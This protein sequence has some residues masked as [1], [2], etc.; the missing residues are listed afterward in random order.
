MTISSTKVFFIFAAV[1]YLVSLVLV[2][3]VPEVKP[4]TRIAFFYAGCACLATG[5]VL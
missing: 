1:F 3:A 5:F 2:L 4:E